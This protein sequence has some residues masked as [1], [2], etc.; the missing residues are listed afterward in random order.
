[1]IY[2]E[3]ILFLSGII[4]PVIIHLISRKRVREIQFSSLSFI[5]RRSGILRNYLRLREPL[6][7]LVRIGMI[8]SLVMALVMKTIPFPF[9]LQNSGR[10]IVDTSLSTMDR[11]N[12][13]GIPAV[14]RNGVADMLKTFETYRYGRLISDMQRISFKGIIKAGKSYPMI[15]PEPLPVVKSNSGITDANY[16]VRPDGKVIIT[17]VVRRKGPP[18]ESFI[19][20]D[21][22]GRKW[23]RRVK[24]FGEKQVSFEFPL[25]PGLHRVQISLPKDSIPFDNVYYL[26]VSVSGRERIAIFTDDIPR[27]LESAM[28]A[29]GLEYTW[30]TKPGYVPAKNIFIL[31]GVNGNLD[32]LSLYYSG[33]IISVNN[34]TRI[35]GVR[36]EKIPQRYGL[37][38]FNGIQ[39]TEPVPYGFLI[40]G[41]EVLLRFS[42]GDPAV[43]LK[44]RF[45]LL[46]FSIQTEEITLHTYF[47][48][49]LNFLIDNIN[50]ELAIKTNPDFFV[51]GPA[52]IT[53]PE[54]KIFRIGKDEKFVFKETGFYLVKRKGV[55]SLYAI[56]PP[57]EEYNLEPLNKREM[58][59]I[60]S[61]QRRYD[62]TIFFLMLFVLLAVIEYLMERR[63][64]G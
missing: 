48:P 41:G 38:E 35:G 1:M 44:D 13:V 8:A 30:S 11:I 39:L 4:I 20:F 57:E 14:S 56:N 29:M 47:I 52:V 60:F 10:K 61:E 15:I 24:I 43:V 9:F 46:P 42:N 50:R 32:Y 64:Y 2:P 5:V 49:F 27:R 6:L 51:S 3:Y 31:D 63:R 19:D 21:I 25:S 16:A 37:F 33:G 7:M 40:R 36:I 28:E 55:T 22:D 58:R 62:G 34:E 17:C 12:E 59:L 23:R 18:V 45:I 54:K 26:P 53:T